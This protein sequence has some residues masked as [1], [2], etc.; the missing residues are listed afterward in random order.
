[1]SCLTSSSVFPL[2]TISSSSSEK[3]N[4]RFTC[5]EVSIVVLVLPLH[6]PVLVLVFE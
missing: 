6:H 4:P 3:K 1:L 5:N 2:I